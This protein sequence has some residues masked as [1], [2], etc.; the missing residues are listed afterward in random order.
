MKLVWNEIERRKGGMWLP[1]LTKHCGLLLPFPSCS[2]L[3]VGRGGSGG[4]GGHGLGRASMKAIGFTC[5][6]SFVSMT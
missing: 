2:A 1:H 3:V 5:K 6:L 4:G